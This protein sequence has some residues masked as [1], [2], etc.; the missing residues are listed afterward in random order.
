MIIA[1]VFD[2]FQVR[3]KDLLDD[4][5]KTVLF[6]RECLDERLRL[7][8]QPGGDINPILFP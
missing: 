1:T 3:Y 2:T 5:H 6:S 7:H 4:V 8:W